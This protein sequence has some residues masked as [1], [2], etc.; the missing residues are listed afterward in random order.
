MDIQELKQT[1]LKE[2]AIAHIHGWDFS[3]IAGRHEDIGELPWSYEQI[4]Q[5]YRRDH[6]K[7][8][9]IDTGGGEVLLTLGHPY[10]NTHATEG[11]PPNVQLCR[12]TLSPLGIHFHEMTDYAH[13]PFADNTFDIIIN[14][15]GSYDAAEIYRT[16]R[17]GG[18][19]I[20]QQV[21]DDNER[22]LAELLL[23]GTP[24]PFP[25]LNLAEQS[26]IF[27]AAGF[28]ILRGDESFRPIRF[29][30]SGALVWFARIIQWEFPGFSVERCFDRLLKAHRLIEQNGY[31]EGT[32]HRYLLIA[33]K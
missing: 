2:E 14:R 3:H 26:S 17:P 13:M 31:V 5:S 16:L 33:Q 25:G 8:L 27:R 1:W 4:V 19:F 10:E 9:D 32:T 6:H 11:Y 22:E 20:T 12:E 18:L 29:Y 15:H 24:K 21:G 30:D 28:T 23:P 7:L